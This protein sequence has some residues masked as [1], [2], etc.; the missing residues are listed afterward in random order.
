MIPELQQK[1]RVF[2]ETSTIMPDADALLVRVER[3]RLR[4]RRVR[5][6]AAM[7][8]VVLAGALLV[9]LHPDLG[10][11]FRGGPAPATID[12]NLPTTLDGTDVDTPPLPANEPVGAASL[13]Y[14][15]CV[16]CPTYLFT[17][18]GQRYVLARTVVEE[19][20]TMDPN[21][22]GLAAAL[23]PDGHWLALPTPQGIA[24]RDL[25]GTDHRLVDLASVS[26]WSG[27]G[28]HV[29]GIRRGVKN[30]VSV[31]LTDGHMSTDV[32]AGTSLILDRG[33][34]IAPA[35]GDSDTSL[36]LNCYSPDP[37]LSTA[38]TVID[39]SGLLPSGES[40]SPHW[41]YLDEHGN[42]SIDVRAAAE[43]SSGVLDRLA[44]TGFATPPGNV[45]DGTGAPPLIRRSVF[46]VRFADR[47]VLGRVDLPPGAGRPVP[48]GDEVVVPVQTNPGEPIVLL[49]GQANGAVHTLTSLPGG[50][51]FI[52]PGMPYAVYGPAYAG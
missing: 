21:S 49:S 24:L 4:R 5:L 18:G 39:V 11:R 37:R 7:A 51:A 42:E 23:S 32:P 44:V 16:A 13:L 31:D 22:T 38:N 6:A 20:T 29:L 47:A 34:T 46:I 17:Q 1:L 45:L 27:D 14:N 26:A 33:I 8:L 19:G 9:T 12:L 52:L 48:L 50:G 28:R 25:T 36:A 40:I 2:A 35:P 3:R 30:L 15:A 10:N 43:V 41:H